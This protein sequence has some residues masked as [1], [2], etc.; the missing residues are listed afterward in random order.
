MVPEDDPGTIDIAARRRQQGA[1][2]CG[3][4]KIRFERHTFT[5]ESFS[6][7]FRTRRRAT[8]AGG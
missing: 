1:F 3:A 7:V 5:S 4:F 2:R 6:Q 8:V